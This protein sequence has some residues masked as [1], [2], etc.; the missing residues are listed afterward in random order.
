MQHIGSRAS[1][2]GSHIGVGCGDGM[3]DA[4][5]AGDKLTMGMMLFL[6]IATCANQKSV[7]IFGAAMTVLFISFWFFG[8]E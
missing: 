8:V 4:M 2:D 7:Q 6:V 5:S 3:V 1:H